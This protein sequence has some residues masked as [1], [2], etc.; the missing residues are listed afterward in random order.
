M[1]NLQGMTGIV[2]M[3]GQNLGAKKTDRA[4]RVTWPTLCMT[5]VCATIA[6]ALWSWDLPSAFWTA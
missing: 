6:A 3:I 5:M 1:G 4:A 2:G